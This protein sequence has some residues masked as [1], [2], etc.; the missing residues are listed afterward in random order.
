[1]TVQ[2]N[3]IFDNGVLRPLEPLLLPDQ[4]LVKL[5]LESPSSPKT[6]EKISAQKATLQSLWQELDR[7]PQPQN[8]DGWSAAQHDEILYGE[9]P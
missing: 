1:M 9:S 2:I 5:T 6:N 4:S 8:N 7:T 3:A